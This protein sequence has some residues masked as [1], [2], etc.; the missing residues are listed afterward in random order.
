MPDQVY[1]D[2]QEPSSCGGER[3]S[4]LT[5]REWAN[6]RASA[7]VALLCPFAFAQTRSRAAV[8]LEALVRP[9]IS[10]FLFCLSFLVPDFFV[11]P[12]FYGTTSN[13]WVPLMR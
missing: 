11:T 7:A 9:K 8:G 3:I 4:H 12:Y 6:A 10:S 1:C 2:I 5:S 13:G